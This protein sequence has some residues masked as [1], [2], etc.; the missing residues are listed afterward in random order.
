MGTISTSHNM[1]KRQLLLSRLAGWKT[2]KPPT[3][4]PK[5]GVITWNVE[6]GYGSRHAPLVGNCC[7]R[8]QFADGLFTLSMTRTG[9]VSLVD[10][11]LRSSCS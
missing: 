11:N 4:N 5:A 9:I 7:I 6:I 1:L 10:S 3:P 8:V 2:R